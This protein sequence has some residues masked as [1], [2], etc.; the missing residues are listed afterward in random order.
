MLSECI[1]ESNLKFVPDD[2]AMGS[3]LFFLAQSQVRNKKFEA[4]LSRLTDCSRTHWADVRRNN[5]LLKFSVAKVLQCLDRHSEA[6]QVFNEALDLCDHT[7]P[8][9]YFRRAWSYKALGDYVAAGDDFETAKKLSPDDP[10][11]AI[12]Y[13]KIGRCAYMQIED[14]PDLVE[15][16]P[17]LLPVPG[18]GIEKSSSTNHA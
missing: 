13:K 3:Q 5:Y 17:P 4:A 11:F 16:F 8:H 6:L 7:S 14:D 12:S 10:N 15:L 1:H 2:I 18:L 9:C